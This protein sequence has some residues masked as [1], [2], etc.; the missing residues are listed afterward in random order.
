MVARHQCKQPARRSGASDS[1]N[2]SGDVARRSVL[3]Q[4]SIF[5]DELFGGTD[6]A[7]KVPE[8]HCLLQSQKGL[9]GASMS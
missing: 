7:G 6:H 1:M 4:R 9:A 8:P 3:A 5:R 2:A